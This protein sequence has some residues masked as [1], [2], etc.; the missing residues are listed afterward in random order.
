M[1]TRR[2][3]PS[4]TNRRVTRAGVV[5]LAV[6]VVI[7]LSALIGTTLILRADAERAGASASLERMRLRALA[8]SGVQAVIAEMEAQRDT[9]LD[10]GEPLLNPEWTLWEEGGRRGVV[11]LQAVHGEDL[12]ESEGAKLDVNKATEAMLALVPGLDAGKA[13]GIVA[14][15][16]SGELG[17]AE[18]I[19]G[20]QDITWDAMYGS[21]DA[22][23]GG[24][25]PGSLVSLLTAFAFDPNIQAGVSREGRES[26]GEERV[27]VSEGW[28]EELKKQLE[29]RLSGAALAAA[30]AVLRTSTVAHE[31]AVVGIARAK[32]G[33]ARV[34]GE[35]LDVL[36]TRDDAFARGRVDVTRA[37]AAVLGCIPGIDAAAAARILRIRSGLATEDLRNVGWLVTDAGLT[38]DQF[39][40]AAAWVTTRTTVWRVRIEA[41]IEAPEIDE[42]R[43]EVEAHRMVWDAVV[44][45][46]GPVARAAYLRD[47]TYL[48]EL[49]TRLE[50]A[51][52]EKER[53][54]AMSPTAESEAS[55]T[56]SRESAAE[57]RSGEAGVPRGGRENKPREASTTRDPQVKD[58]RTEPPAVDAEGTTSGAPVLKD[59]RI[60]RW[61]GR[62]A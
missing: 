6:L 50:R 40:Q 55:G 59:R 61:R 52:A 45:A 21:V 16:G 54:A 56:P 24:D 7:T 32:T 15:R 62:G 60:G 44:D 9:L 19:G 57:P 23:G 25:S 53:I 13:K 47:V 41:S 36:T 3:T 39:Q 27:H 46:S 48:P 12:V 4:L 30:E 37:S 49:R 34:W 58:E 35:V 42:E 43:G 28:S 18:A 1:S 8:W 14:A 31:S 26:R 29:G 11:R 10:G 2:A 20:V 33:D 17:S 38:P 22:T 51:D 5:L